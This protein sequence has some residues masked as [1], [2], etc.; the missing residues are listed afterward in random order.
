MTGKHKTL[1]NKSQ[2]EFSFFSRLQKNARNHQLFPLR[3]PTVIL[4]IFL[5]DNTFWELATFTYSY[6]HVYSGDKKTTVNSVL[7]PIISFTY[8]QICGA[9]I[10]SISDEHNSKKLKF[11]ANKRTLLSSFFWLQ[12]RRKLVSKILWVNL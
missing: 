11:Y 4:S 12:L 7:A 6:P 1:V 3:W 9:G 10:L 8:W 5:K 2:R